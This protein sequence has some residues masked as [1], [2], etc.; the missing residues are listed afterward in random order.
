M[1]RDSQAMM[2]KLVEQ[3]RAAWLDDAEAV[4]PIGERPDDTMAAAL[5]VAGLF[6]GTRAGGTGLR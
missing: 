6:S 5:A 1:R 2:G 4:P 3:G